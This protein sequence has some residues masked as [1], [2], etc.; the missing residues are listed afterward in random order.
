[1]KQQTSNNSIQITDKTIK[2]LNLE[3]I[4]RLE[5]QNRSQ[6]VMMIHLLRNKLTR[7]EPNDPAFECIQRNKNKS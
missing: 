2:L 7:K 6:L 4:R 5:T 3:M 1:M